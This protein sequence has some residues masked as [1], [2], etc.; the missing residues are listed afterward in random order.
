MAKSVL[1]LIIATKKTGSG[2]QEAAR[3]LQKL[4]SQVTKLASGM[5]VLA[6]ASVALGAGRMFAGFA[7]DLVD[8][9][10]KAGV[11]TEEMDEVFGAWERLK[12]AAGE[13]IIL[14]IEA[15]IPEGFSEWLDQQA[16]AIEVQN[17]FNRA[18]TEGR[19]V[20]EEYEV[21]IGKLGQREMTLTKILDTTTGEIIDQEEAIRRLI[22]AQEEAARMSGEMARLQH[23]EQDERKQSEE[24][25]A[26]WAAHLEKSHKDAQKATEEWADFV[27]DKLELTTQELLEMNRS[28]QASIQHWRDMKA[29]AVDA[30]F[31]IDTSVSSTAANYYDQLQFMMAGGMALITTMEMIKEAVALGDIG[32]EQGAEMFKAVVAEAEALN[33]EM[34]KLSRWEAAQNIAQQLNIPLQEALDLLDQAL[35][36]DLIDPGMVSEAKAALAEVEE[37]KKN[38]AEAE[39]IEFEVDPD[40]EAESQLDTLQGQVDDL[41]Q[42]HI[43]TFKIVTEGEM[44][45]VG[46]GAQTGRQWRVRGR[47]GVDNTMVAFPASPGETVTVTP[48][49]APK[50]GVSQVVNQYFYDQ[51]NLSQSTSDT[52]LAEIEAGY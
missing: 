27:A 31:S 35:E 24:G 29:A 36:T 9:A 7:K 19:F 26:A 6:A 30:F 20:V 28:S 34:G 22:G 46:D 2:E 45:D 21:G 37:K 5:K 12:V 10:R 3:D 44:P 42:V 32:M 38:L 47:P 43:I 25:W 18:L 4:D 41:A 52:V 39:G 48:E 51:M 50:P 8:S 1:E 15:A 14:Q 11:A 16:D 17:D 23:I 40:D 13:A 33:V 49:G